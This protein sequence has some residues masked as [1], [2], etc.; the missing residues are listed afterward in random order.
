MAD[1][2]ESLTTC[3]NALNLEDAKSRA[4]NDMLK[5]M[6]Y[7][8]P[9]VVNT[10]MEVIKRYG[11]PEGRE[12]EQRSNIQ[13]III[14]AFSNKDKCINVNYTVIICTDFAILC[15]KSDRIASAHL[16]LKLIKCLH[17]CISPA[18]FYWNTDAS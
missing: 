15:Y 2:L 13:N 14:F 7:V 9:I 10:Q 1:V 16:S 4:G 8:Y 5:V 12:G 6:Q 17:N 3:E 11:L 18:T